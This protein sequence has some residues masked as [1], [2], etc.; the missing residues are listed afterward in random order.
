MK[1]SKLLSSETVAM[2][3]PQP[4]KASKTSRGAGAQLEE[5][6]CCDMEGRE[7]GREEGRKRW[8][9][10]ANKGHGKEREG[11]QGRHHVAPRNKTQRERGV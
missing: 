4:K 8:E 9:G 5:R 10:G 3:P 2:R 1:S 7:E 11:D 6:M